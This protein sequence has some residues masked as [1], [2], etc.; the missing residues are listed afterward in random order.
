[1][2]TSD[3]LGLEQL[4]R[5]V[6]DDNASLASALR[7][8]LMIAGYAHHGELRAWAA[9]ELEGYAAADELPPYRKVLAALEVGKELHLPGQIV[10][11]LTQRISVVQLPQQARD[12][13]LGES[14]PVRMGVRE[15]EGAVARA[16]RVIHLSPA[17]AAEYVL[18][19]T[20]EQQ[21]LGNDSVEITSLYWDMATSSL[22]GVLDQIRTRLAQFVAEVRAAMPPGQQNPNVSQIEAAAQQVLHVTGGNGSTIHVFAPNAKAD[23]GATARASVNDP[24]P[25]AVRS[26]WHRA[27]IWIAFA[28]VV[29]AVVLLVVAR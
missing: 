1:M 9:K 3:V 29:A 10:R 23:R 26:L 7:R 14:A 17:G 27:W 4:E 18:Y 16:D 11:G 13:G 2:T 24:V 5:A 12:R 28:A 22:E 19:M 21:R 25:M 20:R 6:L 15:L 8:C